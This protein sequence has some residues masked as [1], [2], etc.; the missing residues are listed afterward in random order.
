MLT[1]MLAIAMRLTWQSHFDYH[2][3]GLTPCRSIASEAISDHPQ[4]RYSDASPTA[5]T[6]GSPDMLQ[7]LATE[8]LG[9]VRSL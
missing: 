1:A 2:R 6:A 4:P 5:V 7:A 8:H 3:Q 9:V